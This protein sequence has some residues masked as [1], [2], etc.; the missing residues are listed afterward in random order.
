MYSYRQ[1]IQ[2]AL[3]NTTIHSYE[4]NE[5]GWDNVAIIINNEWLFRFPRKSEYAER[6]P[7]EKQLCEV[8]SQSVQKLKIPQYNTLYN[9]KSDS[10]PVCSYYKLIHGKPLTTKVIEKLTTQERET[11]IIQ[12]ATF[13]ASLHTIPIEDAVRWKFTS[14]KPISYWQEIQKKLHDYLALT[15]TS[16]ERET[17]DYLFEGFFEHTHASD[18]KRTIIH[19]DFTHRHILF[20]EEKRSIAGI[21]DFGDAQIGDPAFDFAGL[22]NDFGSKFTDAIY[23]QYCNLT[24]HHDSSFL[25]RVIQFYQYSPLLHN[26]IHSF[27]ANNEQEIQKNQRKLQMILQGTN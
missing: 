18:F 15:L 3:P 23:K 27:E 22:Y 2:Q 13:L 17:F 14:E 26:L 9:N 12:V 7:R 25:K 6:I 20:D 19:A 16:L 1:Y 8:L 24:P 10:I 5:N 21:I 11:V 4:Q